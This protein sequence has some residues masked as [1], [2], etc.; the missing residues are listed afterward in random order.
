MN[1]IHHWW[2][3]TIW[4]IEA[5]CVI[6]KVLA[7]TIDLPCRIAKGC[8]YCTRDDASSCLVRFGI[9]RYALLIMLS[10]K[11]FNTAILSRL[12]GHNCKSHASYHM[13][14]TLYLTSYLWSLDAFLSFSLMVSLTQFVNFV[15]YTYIENNHEQIQ[16]ERILLHLDFGQWGCSRFSCLVSFNW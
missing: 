1:D 6:L 15:N 16:V 8:K 12:H 7:D 11:I 5:S 4:F 13:T 3:I 14:S 10:T 9:D 2:I